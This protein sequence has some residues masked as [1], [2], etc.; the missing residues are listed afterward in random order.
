M[1]TTTRAPAEPRTGSGML[2]NRSAWLFTTATICSNIVWILASG[3]NRDRLTTAGVLLFFAASLT[4]SLTVRGAKWTA[5]FFSTACAFGWAVEA[6]GTATGVPFGAYDYTDRLGWSV[7]SVPLLIPLAWAMMAYPIYAAVERTGWGRPVRVLLSAALL[8]AWDLFLDPQMVAEGHWVW[9][10]AEPALPGVPGIPLTNFAGW[11]AASLVLMSLLTSVMA[12]RPQS[13]IA[14]PMVLL[15][16]VYAGN[17]VANA[18][19]L[20]RPA[21]ALVGAVGM[22]IPMLVLTLG[23]RRGADG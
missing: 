1:S 10:A 22:G 16:W 11:I 18:V 20:G 5:V 4:H 8:A 2:G 3:Q 21:V 12:P 17:I 15:G 13:P 6:L 19:F 14:V 7:G 9:E 23:L